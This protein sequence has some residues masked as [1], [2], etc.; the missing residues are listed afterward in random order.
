MVS[1]P[2]Q[3]L[4]DH[5]GSAVH[6]LVQ[7]IGAQPGVAQTSTGQ[8][9]AGESAVV[10]AVASALLANINYDPADSGPEQAPAA[11][12]AGAAENERGGLNLS[13]PWNRFQ[14]AHKGKGLSNSQMARLYRSENAKRK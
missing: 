13:N 11:S 9:G 5:P 7:A 8:S 2:A 6:G 12:S 1:G 10:S 4:G 14:H 3:A